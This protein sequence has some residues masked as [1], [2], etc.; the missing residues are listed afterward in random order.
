MEE[1][2]HIDQAANNHNA[3]MY[4]CAKQY[5]TNQCF[6]HQDTGEPALYSRLVNAGYA[7]TVWEE[8]IAWGYLTAQ[9]TLNGWMNSSG[10]RA[11]ILSNNVTEIGCSLLNAKNGNYSGMYWTC[12]FGK[13]SEGSTSIITK[14]T[15]PVVTT[16]PTSTH[17]THI[18]HTAIITPSPPPVATPEALVVQ[19]DQPQSITSQIVSLYNKILC[20]YWPT[21]SFCYV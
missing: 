11:N 5:G 2:A 12:D 3:T 1:N 18:K 8:N 10:H 16:R 14:P 4:S 15:T 9:D 19:Q 20:T 7:P 17:T 13:G 6:S 21:S